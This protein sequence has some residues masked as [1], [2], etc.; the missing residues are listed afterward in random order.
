[1][2]GGD[3]AFCLAVRRNRSEALRIFLDLFNPGKNKVLPKLAKSYALA[4]DKGLTDLA[5][6][7]E[8]SA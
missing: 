8:Y 6:I 4:L 7:K 3:D 5:A 1:M 2:E